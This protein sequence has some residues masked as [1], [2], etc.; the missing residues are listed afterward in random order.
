MPSLTPSVE[1]ELIFAEIAS[2]QTNTLP[3]IE[4]LCFCS[5]IIPYLTHPGSTGTVPKT[6]RETREGAAVP[7]RSHTWLELTTSDSSS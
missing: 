2:S 1:M 5:F 7:A 4:G 6:A 3:I